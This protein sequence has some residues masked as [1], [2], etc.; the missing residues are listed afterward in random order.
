M[1]KYDE[2]VEGLVTQAHN[3]YGEAEF[4]DV[5]VAWDAEAWAPYPSLLDHEMTNRF[6]PDLV[7]LPVKKLY[8]PAWN[9]E[10]AKMLIKTQAKRKLN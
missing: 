6:F 7:V 5:V 1:A 9:V 10:D 2:I 8:E 4:T 3:F